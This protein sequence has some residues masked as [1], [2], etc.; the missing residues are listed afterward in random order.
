MIVTIRYLLFYEM[1][2]IL[3]MV[4]MIVGCCFPN[5]N[6]FGYV[7]HVMQEVLHEPH[8]VEKFIYDV[9]RNMIDFERYTDARLIEINKSKANLDHVN[10]IYKQIKE[11][12]Y[13]KVAF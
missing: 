8:I 5:R 2:L 13:G 12:P 3:I 4:G 1:A 7:S 6:Q 10:L 9:T 11:V